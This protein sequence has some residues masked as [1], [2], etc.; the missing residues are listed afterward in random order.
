[1]Q[2]SPITIYHRGFLRQITVSRVFHQMARDTFPAIFARPSFSA[3]F[4]YLLFGTFHDRHSQRLLLPSKLIAMFEGRS[5]SNTQAERFLSSFSEVLP[6]GC[7]FEWSHFDYENKKCRQLEVFCLGDFEEII[8]EERMRGWHDSGRVYLDGSSF[9]AKKQRSFHLQMQRE[10]LQGKFLCHHAHFIGNYLNTLSPHLFNRTVCMNLDAAE[11]IAQTLKPVPRESQ[12]RLLRYI[13]HNSQPFYHSGTNSVR[14]FTKPS[15]ANLERNVRKALTRGWTEGDLKHSQLAICAKLWTIREIEE[16]LM[17]GGKFWASLSKD[18]GIEA[19]DIDNVKPI[20]KKRLYSTCYGMPVE[21]VRWTGRKDLEEANLNP[22]IINDFIAHPLI[23]AIFRER[24]VEMD[25]IRM[26][27]GA[28]DAY[29]T[30]LPI[31][32]TRWAR[33]VMAAVAQSWEMKLI[34]PVFL[35]AAKTR[36]FTITLFQHDGFSVNF[37]R[38]KD[39]WKNRLEECVNNKAIEL[40]IHTRLEWEDN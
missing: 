5:P 4:W 7:V 38:R 17:A 19:H 26:A 9:S 20:L 37:R 36:E 14:L 15:I 25:R 6:N 11:K 28:Y 31:Q 12:T 23:Q 39:A 32:G 16:F 24:Q 30:W 22:A 33:D 8:A 34:F 35:L 3:L 40:D 10:A 18:I 2:N 29:G 1:M 13:E 27:R 21:R